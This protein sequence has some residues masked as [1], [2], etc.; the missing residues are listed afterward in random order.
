MKVTHIN[1]YCTGG[2]AKACLRIARAQV[3]SG[4]DGNMLVLYKT[5]KEDLITD[6][7]N[8]WSLMKN[9]EL[10]IRNKLFVWK[11]N[12]QFYNKEELFSSYDP[13][14]DISSHSLVE[15]ADVINL[16]WVSGFV[17]FNSFFKKV[18]KKIIF[19]LHDHYPFSG[20]Y[21]YPN[22]YF[23]TEKFRSLINA[24][25]KTLAALYDNCNIHFVGPSQYIIDQFNETVGKGK[26]RTSVIKN[27]VDPAVFYQKASNELRSEL[28]I[29]EKEKVLLFLNEHEHYKRKGS[30]LLKEIIPDLCNAGYRI[31]LAGAKS[32]SLSH[33]SVIQTGYLHS[34]QQLNEYYN[35]ADLVLFPSLDDNLPN[36]I[37]EAHSAG[38][39]VL[40]FN[41]GGVPEM[42]NEGQ[43]GWLVK[44]GDIKAFGSKIHEVLNFTPDRK[45]IS[46]KAHDTYSEKKATQLY[47]EVYK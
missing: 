31:I 8:E 43:N 30:H 2:A 14:W 19:T 3:R 20:G 41:A 10:K 25:R 35:L 12:A 1:T 11:Q 27:P 24:N 28:G 37:S 32:D 23:E 7:R 44:K 34:D 16:H 18:K 46:Q 39:P 36:V 21:H 42:I 45:D 9:Y 6:A 40:A 47:M 26:F 13:V 38:T 15:N 29:K 33:P 17:N 22:P 4:I 5:N